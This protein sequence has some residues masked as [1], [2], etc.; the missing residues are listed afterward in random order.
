MTHVVK[1][2]KL[3]LSGCLVIKDKKVLLLY[4]KNHEHYETPGGKVNLDECSNR[5]D[6]S[7]E[8][9]RKAAERELYEELGSDIKVKDLEYFGHADFVI[10]D[11]RLAIA[12]KF[13]T[14]IISG[15]P[16]LMEP[17][18]FSKFDY[19]DISKLEE[20]PI[21]PDLKLLLDKIKGLH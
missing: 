15:E 17:D 2:G 4:K 14:E 21:S 13:V 18:T 6:P 5:E 20:Y 7:E 16:K 9:L 19:L 1:D 8:D 3:I 11:G 10:P 12:H